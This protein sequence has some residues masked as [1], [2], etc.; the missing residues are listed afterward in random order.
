MPGS[1]RPRHGCL[2]R[3]VEPGR[4]ESPNLCLPRHARP[5][6]PRG[7]QAQ[8]RS[9]QGQTRGDLGAGRAG[10]DWARGDLGAGGA[11]ARRGRAQGRGRGNRGRAR[12]PTAV[13]AAREHAPQT[14]RPRGFEQEAPPPAREWPISGRS[15]RRAQRRPFV[16][17][18]WR[19][20]APPRAVGR[21]SLSGGKLAAAAVAVAEQ[22]T[23][24]AASRVR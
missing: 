1:S 15:A 3:E 6:A 17:A 4:S 18:E 11:W 5:R 10:P 16:D 8:A 23:R 22:R 9:V 7:P 14:P 21:S 24:R 2:G 13:A 19:S 12:A 20:L